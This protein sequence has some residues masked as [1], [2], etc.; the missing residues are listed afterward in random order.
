VVRNEAGNVLSRRGH[1][2]F[3]YINSLNHFFR[4][5]T[6]IGSDVNISFTN[7]RAAGNWDN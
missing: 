2:V 5:E 4:K 7:G 3:A 1:A 6:T